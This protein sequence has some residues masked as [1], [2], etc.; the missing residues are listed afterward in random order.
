MYNMY[1]PFNFFNSIFPIFFIIIF[2]IIVVIFIITIVKVIK[3]WSYNNSQPKIPAEVVVVAKRQDVR[4]HNNVNNDI[5]STRS[6][7]SY[8]VTFEF[9]N[10]E[11][12]ELNLSA[13]EYGLLAE[14]DT[15]MLVS[16]GKRFISF[17]REFNIINKN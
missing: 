15:G 14:G 11:R 12:L 17:D 6:I 16:Q 1:E 3:E 9:N 5:H 8:Y 2:G 4:R 10:G 13:E 7:T